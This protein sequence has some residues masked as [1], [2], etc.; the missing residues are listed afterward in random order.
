MAWR[1]GP[2]GFD[3]AVDFYDETRGLSPEAS[4]ATTDLLAF[5]LRDCKRVLE[6]GIGT[7][8]MAL[9]LV[10][11]GFHVDGIDLSE[12]MLQR[13]REKISGSPISIAVAD[14]TRLPFRTGSV[15][16]AYLRHVLHLIPDWR[17]AV[18]E[19]VRV[20]RPGGRILVSITDYT[21]LYEEVQ[22]RFRLEAGGL[23]EAVGLQPDDPGSLIAAMSKL[24]ARGH[25]LP[26]IRGSRALT[27]NQFLEHI[28]RGHYTW[29]WPATEAERR[30][31]SRR[32]RAWLA[33]RFG[34]L[35]RPVE[36]EYTVEWWAFDL[37]QQPSK[38]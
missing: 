30:G 13:L 4:R 19:L 14:A 34:D 9:P 26:P 17:A 6:V 5:Q 22:K 37:S 12:P 15:E 10:K 35:D 27:L 8:L 16:G 36:P 7:G 28:E 21:G 24:G 33:R 3:H 29:T 31:A 23:P 20:V 11:H 2:I 25:R 38:G 32:V 1:E 18:A